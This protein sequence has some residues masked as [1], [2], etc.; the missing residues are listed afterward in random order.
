MIVGRFLFIVNASQFVVTSS[1]SDVYCEIGKLRA[2]HYNPQ[3]TPDSQRA[4]A[5]RWVETLE[6]AITTPT[7]VRL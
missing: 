6:G 2:A 1:L 4:E 5:L 3:T 7:A